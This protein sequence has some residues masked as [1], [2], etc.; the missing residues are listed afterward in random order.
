VGLQLDDAVDEQERRPVR[1]NFL[2]FI[3]VQDHGA[4][5]VLPGWNPQGFEAFRKGLGMPPEARSQSSPWFFL[6]D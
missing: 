2:Y 1:Q 3:D 6:S 5:T 4:P